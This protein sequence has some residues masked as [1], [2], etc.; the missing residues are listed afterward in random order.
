MASRVSRAWQ[1][2]EGRVFD[3]TSPARFASDIRGKEFGALSGISE[4]K[5]GMEPVS[6]KPVI[7][8]TLTFAGR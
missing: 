5:I 4:I 7:K 8:V 2:A 6:G 3:A 1:L